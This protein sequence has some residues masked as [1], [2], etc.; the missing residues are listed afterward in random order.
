MARI[1]TV[2]PEF[3]TDEKVVECSIP[4][5]LLFI[6]LFNFA[7]DLG[8][9]E[10]SPKRIKMQIFPADSIDCEPL[11]CELITHGLLIEYSVSG[12]DYL[13]IKGFS[14][15][16]KINRPSATKIP[17][18]LALTEPEV[19]NE[20]GISE[21]SV[22]PHGVINESSL[23]D[24]DTDTEGKVIT[25]SLSEREDKNLVQPHQDEPQKPRYL[26][27][28]DE[29]IGK[30]TMTSAW[31]P[32]RDFR[33]RAAMWGIALPEPVYHPTELAEFA[34]YW[35]SEGKVFTQV[36]WE[37]KFARHIVLVR[38]KKQPETGG[39]DNAGVRG[40]PTASRAVQQIQ[41]AHA[42]WRRR[43][44]LDG[45][46]NGMAP[47]AGHGGNILEPVDAEEW[48]GAFGALDSPNRF[49]E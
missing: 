29:P 17:S 46:G 25:P 9:L 49:D 6:G 33:Q 32:S 21:D 1:R 47:V 5:R 31:L 43:N 20:G 34:S 27:G 13:C 16:Q 48:G 45:N 14:K 30:F 22:S 42:E 10:R 3:W 12:S 39:K 8:C 44:G 23:T 26:E 24:T 38:S 4:A 15:H 37:Q 36:Q 19:K 28:L 18:P 41:S 40:E 7:N 11:I 35:E 2:K